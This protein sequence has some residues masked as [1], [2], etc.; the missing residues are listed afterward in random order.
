MSMKARWVGLFLL[1]RCGG[2]QPHAGPELSAD[3][4]VAA[5]GAQGPSP[6]WNTDIQRG[7]AY[8]QNGKAEEAKPYF[9]KVLRD[10]PD[11]A[12]ASY[13]LGVAQETLGDRSAAERSYLTALR[14]DPHF[15]D[16]AQNLAALYLEDPKR[17][18]DA[19]RV[20][21]GLGTSIEGHPKVFQILGMAQEATGD[22]ASAIKSYEKAL[23]LE[24][25]SDVHFA[26]GTL[27]VK[28]KEKD[29]AA[30][31]F[32]KVLAGAKQDDKELLASLGRQLGYAGAY[33]ECVTALD[34]AIA[35]VHKDPE[36]LVRRG[37][38]KHELKKEADAQ[39]DYNRAIE[40]QKNFAPAYYYL[41]LSYLS[42]HKPRTAA[43]YLNKAVEFAGSTE[44]APKAKEKLGQ[45]QKEAKKLGM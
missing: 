6:T 13:Y 44:L 38:C 31:H 9:E 5:P 34:R 28:V 40:V 14:V 12:E 39:A 35:L 29:K 20:L 33:A 8:L 11:S 15:V 18:A 25:A 19:V 32:K 10:R 7:V 2:A 27:L 37:T 24:D 4:P 21:K 23:A 42:M 43:F 45:A 30:E 3:P 17:P 1:A 41:G 16:A 22:D 26:L 36:L